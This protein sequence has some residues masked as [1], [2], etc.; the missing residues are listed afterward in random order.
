MALNPRL[1]AKLEREREGERRLTR[2]Q[3]EGLAGLLPEG[4]VLFDEPTALH[5]VA[6]VGGPVEAFVS[7]NTPDELRAVMGWAQ[8]NAVD[9][10]FWGCGAFTLVRDGG[11][12]GLMIELGE[13]FRCASVERFEGDAAFVSVGAAAKTSELAA[14]CESNGLAGAAGLAS[15][16]G[17]LASLLCANP[18]PADL[19]LEGI[20]EEVTLLTREMR[21]LSL[22]GKALRFEGGRLKIPSTAAVTKLLL[23]FVRSA[24]DAVQETEAAMGEAERGEDRPHYARAFVSETKTAARDLIYDT[25]LS[26][27]RVGGA[28]LSSSFADAIVNEGDAK[29][30]E[31]AVLIGL[32]KDRVREDTGITIASTIEIIGER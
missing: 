32:V 26:G 20:V 8:E 15:A 25:G 1:R 27:V 14:F 21:E 28:R 18:L 13:G 7:I 30:R 10:R 31:M 2:E 23:R 22:R 11:L 4:Q 9:Y 19:S 17:T 3:K 16:Q 5:S 24:E 6:R 12:S 29:A